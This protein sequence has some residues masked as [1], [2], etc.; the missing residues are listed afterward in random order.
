MGEVPEFGCP[1]IS[2]ACRSGEEEGE[3]SGEEGLEL[4]GEMEC[5][6]IGIARRGIEAKGSLGLAVSM[7]MSDT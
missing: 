1:G 2:V 7:F 5:D 4:L 3:M 6:V